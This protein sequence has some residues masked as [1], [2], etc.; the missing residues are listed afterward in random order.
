MRIFLLSH[1][2]L[3]PIEYTRKLEPRTGGHLWHIGAHSL[4]KRCCAH[5]ESLTI[6]TLH[7]RRDGVTITGI[8]DGRSHVRETEYFGLCCTKMF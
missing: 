8:Y 6:C 1:A 5:Y 4:R 7:M 3:T 2:P